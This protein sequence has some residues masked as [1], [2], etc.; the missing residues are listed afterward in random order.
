LALREIDQIL[1][2]ATAS[3]LFTKAKYRSR[4]DRTTRYVNLFLFKGVSTS[5]VEVSCC[6]FKFVFV[7]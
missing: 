6:V 2:T 7:Y 5:V 4:G 1:L 3:F